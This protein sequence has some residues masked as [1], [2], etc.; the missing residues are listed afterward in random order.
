[1]ENLMVAGHLRVANV[2]PAHREY[3]ISSTPS[4]PIVAEAAAQVLRGQN[5]VD[6]LTRNV[7]DGLIEKGQ[8]GELVARLLLTLAHDQ[9]VENMEIT[10]K[11]NQGQLEKLY[12]SPIPVVAFFRALFSPQYV[13]QL[14]LRRADNSPAGLTF[15][16]AFAD[17]YV[18]FTHFGKAADDWC[19]SHTFMFMALC[20]NMAISCREGMEYADLCIPIHFDGRALLSRDTTSAILVSIKDKGDAMSSNR[21][22]VDVNKMAFTQDGTIH[23]FIILILQLGVQAKGG[24]MPIKIT[25]KQGEPGLLAT[26]ERRGRGGAFIPW[27]PIA[28]EL[29]HDVEP[30]DERTTTRSMGKNKALACYTIDVRGCS[31]KIFNVI[32]AEDKPLFDDLLASRNFLSE[33]SRQDTDHLSAVLAQKPVWTRGPECCSWAELTT[34]PPDEPKEEAADEDNIVFGNDENAVE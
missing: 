31:S 2:I 19:M 27:T 9:A 13:D 20:R 24:F 12:T 18:M 10:H 17:A 3:V 28:F 14:L 7:R 30:T 8:R 22:F 26:P 15:E 33:H 21:T 11:A 16:Q 29:P 23:P 32:R 1:M 25:K 6:I 34:K 5:M 4:E